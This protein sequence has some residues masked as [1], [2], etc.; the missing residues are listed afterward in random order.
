[1]CSQY[2]NQPNETRVFSV[3]DLNNYIY[4]NYYNDTTIKFD[5]N[6]YDETFF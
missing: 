3:E 5:V 4:E 6:K 2:W 1:M